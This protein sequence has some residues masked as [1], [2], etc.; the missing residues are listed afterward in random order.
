MFRRTMFGSVFPL[1]NLVF[2]RE[3]VQKAT[4]HLQTCDNWIMISRKSEILERLFSNSSLKQS[5]LGGGG[6]GEVR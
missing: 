2:L 1:W 3:P 5:G 6:K 4:F